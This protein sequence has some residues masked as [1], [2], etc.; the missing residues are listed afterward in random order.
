M[1][2]K[3]ALLLIL[4]SALSL[5]ALFFAFPEQTVENYDTTLFNSLVVMGASA[6][7]GFGTGKEIGPGVNDVTLSQL[8]DRMIKTENHNVLDASSLMFFMSPKR[9]G[10]ELLKKAIE[11]KPTCVIALDYLFWYAYGSKNNIDERQECLAEGLKSLE[12]FECPVV[13]SLLPDMHRSIGLMLSEKQVPSANELKILNTQI[14]EWANNRSNIAVAPLKNYLERL[15]SNQSVQA[16]QEK[17]DPP[18]ALKQLIQKDKLHPTIIGLGMMAAMSIDTLVNY[19]SLSKS[20]FNFD[21]KQ[22]AKKLIHDLKKKQ[23]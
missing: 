19:K 18:D 4:L 10:A 6:S 8:L 2:L 3:R 22:I 7:G 21:A 13:I 11:A 12:S 23:P 15:Y 17:W 14:Q 16:A 5:I 9:K 1:N 20:M